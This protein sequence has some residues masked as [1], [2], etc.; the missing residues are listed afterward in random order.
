MIY[1]GCVAKIDVVWEFADLFNGL[2]A[3]PNLLAL[4]ILAPVVKRLTEDFFG[5]PHRI[6]AKNE[7]FKKR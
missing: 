6:R 3:V 7:D 2:M 4:I 1:F 5:D